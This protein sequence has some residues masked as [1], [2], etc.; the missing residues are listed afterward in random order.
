MCVCVPVWLL[1]LIDFTYKKKHIESP[2]NDV[3]HFWRPK[4]FK[5]LLVP[6]SVGKVVV[7]RVLQSLV[8]Q[9]SIDLGPS[10]FRAKQVNQMLETDLTWPSTNPSPKHFRS[11]KGHHKYMQI[12]K[13]KDSIRCCGKYQTFTF[14]KHILKT[15]QLVILF[16]PHLPLHFLHQYTTPTPKKDNVGC[17]PRLP[18][19]H[20]EPGKLHT[21]PWAQIP[22]ISIHS[23]SIDRLRR[24]D[25][26][27]KHHPERWF[28]GFL[29]EVEISWQTDHGD[30]G[31]RKNE[32]QYEHM[33]WQYVFL[34]LKFDQLKVSE[35]RTSNCSWQSEVPL[36]LFCK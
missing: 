30:L 27:C 32:L 11:E 2:S 36:Q 13:G 12:S 34:F 7:G 33:S 1:I 8:I 4:G 22:L 18:N 19:F 10:K 29:W 28:M 26:R 9:P 17:L 16:F 5:D 3:I 24:K 35:T 15:T 25:R 6:K 31:F 23:S 21:K 14:Q 20:S